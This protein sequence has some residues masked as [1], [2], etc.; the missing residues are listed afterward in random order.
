[1]DPDAFPPTDGEYLDMLSWDEIMAYIR[2]PAIQVELPIY[3]GTDAKTLEKGVGHLE[4]TSIPVGGLGSHAVL[5]AHCGLP[6][7]VL[8]TNLEKLI[9]GDVFYI[10][11]L[12]MT[13][14]YEVYDIEVVEPTDSSS[15][16]PKAGEDLVTLVTCTP[17]GVNSHRL[18][19]HAKRIELDTVPEEAATRVAETG[20]WW[21]QL[22]FI[23]VGVFCVI[24][25][26]I[27]LCFFLLG[28]KRRKQGGPD[29]TQA[30]SSLKP[31]KEMPEKN[32]STKRTPTEKEKGRHFRE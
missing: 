10:D 19:V 14:A 7:A 13:L 27:I 23:G 16:Y 32:R 20:N 31:K 26:V 25:I 3:H 4:N 9:V 8:F 15:L 29:D 17:Y 30:G 28:R 12:N 22:A 24:F 11:V 6:T 21:E 18:L 1:M 2:I 5:S